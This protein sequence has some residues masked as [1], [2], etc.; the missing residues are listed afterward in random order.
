MNTNEMQKNVEN[1]FSKH[2]NAIRPDAQAFDE[3]RII[4]VPRY[5]QSGLSGDEWR[6]SVETQFYRKGVLI[7]SI[8]H[9]NIET[10]CGFAYANYLGGIDDGK[11]YFAGDGKT[12]DQEGCSNSATVKYRLIKLFSREGYESTPY[13][14]TYRH[15]CDKHSQRGDC[16][17]EDADRNYEIIK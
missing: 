13:T 3:V 8:G 14:K 17:L 7:F 10:A 11:A 4:T 12:C 5:K 16:A 9:R 15:F 2:T 6:I 1:K